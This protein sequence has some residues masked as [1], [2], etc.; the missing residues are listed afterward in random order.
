MTT[1]TYRADVAVIGSGI[2]GSSCALILQRAGL[3]VVLIDQGTH[4]RFALG[5]STLPPTSY[6][7][8]LLAER[9]NVPE[10]HTISIAS[11]INEKVAPTS[12]V[13]KNFGFVYHREGAASQD[14]AWQAPIIEVADGSAGES[15]L[16]RQD[17]NAYLFYAALS[18]GVEGL[19]DTRTTEVEYLDEGIR[20]KT[21]R[22]HVDAKFL[23]DASGY[24]SVLSEQLG[25]RETP[26]SLKSQ[27][28]AVF[29]HMV[30]VQPYDERWGASKPTYPWH[31]GT[32]HHFFDGGWIWVIPF[33]NHSKS[34][35]RLCSVGLN[36]DMRKYPYSPELSAEDEWQQFMERFPSFGWQFANAKAVRPWIKSHRLQYSNHTGIGPR[37]WVTPHAY[38]TVNALYSRGM[39]NAF[40]SLNPACRAIVKAIESND[41][42]TE[43]FEGLQALM[44]NALEIQDLLVYGTYTAL[45]DT[46]L[47]DRWLVVWSL[48]ESISIRRILP[49][50]REYAKSKAREWLDF[51]AQDTAMCVVNIEHVLPMLQRLGALMDDFVQ[52]GKTAAETLAAIDRILVTLKETLNVD[53]QAVAQYLRDF[54]KA[55]TIEE[56]AE[57]RA[58]GLAR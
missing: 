14:R 51:D 57:L 45:A 6:W 15:H 46:E 9:W 2:V 16:F 32:L 23:V 24:R 5:E 4:P 3:S 11:K 44:R 53:W 1:K 37:Y 10:L 34:K 26:S 19:S 56:T 12:G 33:D 36:L 58:L 48:F 7:M 38:G 43:P 52:G 54:S 8:T 27:T 40:Q 20:L 29:T 55:V 49:P 30:N 18:A 47:L 25:L 50:L 42:S 41:F 35:N 28:R 31:Q 13:K 39:L 17:V 22:G 21:S